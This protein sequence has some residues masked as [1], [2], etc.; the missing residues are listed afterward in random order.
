MNTFLAIDTRLKYSD[1]NFVINRLD[2]ALGEYSNKNLTITISTGSQNT[3]AHE[4]GH[5]L[6]YL[7]AREMGLDIHGLSDGGYNF[8]YIKE[9]HNI[10]DEHIKWAKEFIT[11]VEKLRTKG[12][13]EYIAERAHD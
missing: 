2:R 13:I 12:E 4:I 3:V 9:K 1:L 11:I 8:E 6:D 5:Y 10:F 7:F